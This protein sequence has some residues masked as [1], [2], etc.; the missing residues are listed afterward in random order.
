MTSLVLVGGFLGA[1]KTR[2]LLAAGNMLRARGMRAAILTNDQG[3]EL[4]DTRLAAASGFETGEVA[5]GCFCCRFSDFI[6]AAGRLAAADVILAEP[7]GSCADISATI[8]QPLKSWY[9]ARFRLAP[10][11]VL[12]DPAR[13]RELLAA[14]PD[15]DA[16][17]LF[18]SQLLEADIVAFSKADI[19]RDTPDLPAAVAP[20]RISAA[21][22]EGV[23][24]WLDETLGGTL[25]AGSRL[26]D[27]DYARYARAEASL[28]W[29]NWHADVRLRHPLS[30]AA[31][32]GPLLDNLDSAL[33]LAGA[34]IAHLKLFG[35]APTGYVRA[36]ICANGE[37]PGVEGMLDAS[38]ARVI[39]VVL[40]LRATAAPE[41]LLDIV[42]RTVAAIPGKL[43]IL[44][45][46]AFR[47]AAP[48]PEHRFD[49]LV[50]SPQA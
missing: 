33:T 37:E 40:N 13:A 2:L 3:G 17:Y 31:V 45:R 4:V 20:R 27:I 29:L 38:P 12:V 39:H 24:A 21:T 49:T 47:P 9:G 41:L 23:A 1:G 42:D 5:G 8:L 6:A 28:G 30:P 32:V 25:R 34:R 50:N 7:V 14:D 19:H 10:F 35:Q 44:H 15:S 36:G 16:A 11:T 43:Q 48:M 22:G 46:N 18:R 26:L